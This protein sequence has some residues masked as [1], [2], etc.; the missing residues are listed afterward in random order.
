MGD[1]PAPND[2]R[3]VT[4]TPDQNRK[5]DD[6]RLAVFGLSEFRPHQ[7][8]II[9][10]A[11][12]GQPQLAVLATGAGKSLCYQLPALILPRPVLV[13][14]PLLALMKDQLDRLARLGIAAESLHHAQTASAQQQILRRWA[15]GQLRLLYAAPERLARSGFVRV[16][17]DAPPGLLVVDEAHCISEWGY[18]FRPD[19][20]RLRLFREVVGLPPVLALTATATPRVRADIL[21]QLGM[22]EDS[23]RVTEG[24]VD[25]P[26]IHLAVEEFRSETVRTAAV[27]TA[28]A[29][30]A[31]AVIIYVD[32]RQRAAAWAETLAKRLGEPVAKYHAGL[33]PPERTRIQEDFLSG[34][35]R[36]VAATT[37]FGMGIDRPDIELIVHVGVPESIDTYYQEIGRAGRDGRA[38]SAR[39]CILPDDVRRR[40]GFLRR[41]RPDARIVSGLLDRV[42]ATGGAAPVAAPAG[43]ES[44]LAAAGAILEDMAVVESVTRT[45]EGTVL[46]LGAPIEPWTRAAVLDRLSRQHGERHTRWTAMRRYLG[47]RSCRRQILVAYYGQTSSAEVGGTDACCDNCRRG[48]Y[49][50]DSAAQAGDG[51]RDLGSRLRQWR[52][53]TARAAGIPAYCVLKDRELDDIVHKRPVTLTELRQC[54]GVGPVKLARYGEELC[55]L[56]RDGDGPGTP[57]APP[58]LTGSSRDQAWRLFAEGVPFDQVAVR[59]GQSPGTVRRHLAQ[60]IQAAPD[61]SWRWYLG[62]WVTREDLQEITDALKDHA[63][64][65]RPAYA[66]LQGRFSF[67]ILDVVRAALSRLDPV[68]EPD[69]PGRPAKPRH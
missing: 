56:V 28:I 66:Q 41:E 54:R 20:R 33:T 69:P 38:A 29:N 48:D 49:T 19:Y 16:M 27:A 44:L 2:T 53:D 24:P 10:R 8:E 57:G 43:R 65:L 50:R 64:R 6:L 67:A 12:A 62:R 31:G 18:D 30:T 35:L 11:V 7:R 46:R 25:R 51:G 4:L 17:A 3:D 58:P 1:G 15:K 13:V 40:T 61:A 68:R 32:S 52:T 60:W 14:S 34:R 59:L 42:V 39:M 55:A 26:N 36:V 9:A 23:C 47:A 22:T 63:G 5:I 21:H 45:R 37:A